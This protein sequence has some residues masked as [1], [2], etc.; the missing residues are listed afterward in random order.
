MALVK[1]IIIFSELQTYSSAVQSGLQ[2]IY[3]VLVCLSC[4]WWLYCRKRAA[5]DQTAKAE[6]MSELL[7]QTCPFL[8]TVR[9]TWSFAS[10]ILVW[11]I[12]IIT[13]DKVYSLSVPLSNLTFNTY[14]EEHEMY[15]WRIKLQPFPSLM[16]A[17]NISIF[18]CPVPLVTLTALVQRPCYQHPKSLLCSACLAL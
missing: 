15:T 12:L 4:I 5:V 7:T 13:Q 11:V 8:H 18:I 17:E 1:I 14:P 6:L 3:L 10:S 2:I 16:G 9:K